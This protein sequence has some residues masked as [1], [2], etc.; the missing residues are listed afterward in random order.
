MAR[1][2]LFSVV[3][4]Y[5]IPNR[6]S[7]T[8]CCCRINLCVHCTSV[9]VYNM[10]HGRGRTKRDAIRAL[11]NLNIDYVR[12][13]NVN[14]YEPIDDLC[15]FNRYRLNHLRQYRFDVQCFVMFGICCVGVGC[16]DKHSKIV[17]HFC[18]Y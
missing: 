18:F 4:V 3:I 14:L 6:K 8:K 11:K 7:K 5:C 9:Q 12:S 2:G 16:C 15:L 10:Q 17:V 13:L 1:H